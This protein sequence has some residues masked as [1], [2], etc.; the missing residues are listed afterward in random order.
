MTRTT[1]ERLLLLEEQVAGTKEDVRAIFVKLEDLS[2]RL[3]MRPSWA[4]STLL[5]LL[6]STTVGLAV[7]LA[8]GR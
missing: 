4:V 7:A 1:E 2:N 3:V 5:T 8:T 6:S